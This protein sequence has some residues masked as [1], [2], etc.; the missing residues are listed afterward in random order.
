MSIAVV[1]NC[2][3]TV[4]KKVIY[5]HGAPLNSAAYTLLSQLTLA[6]GGKFTEEAI[7]EA[8]TNARS[9]EETSRTASV[10]NRVSDFAARRKDGRV[11]GSFGLAT[12]ERS[13]LA[14]KV[15]LGSAI[16]L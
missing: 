13:V 3:P 4:V 15:Q 10:L 16:G 7:G 1:V 5:D 11:D 2:P 8:G 6:L 14:H 12:G 9:N